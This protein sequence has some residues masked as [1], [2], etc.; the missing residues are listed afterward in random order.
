MEGLRNPV[1]DEP[2]EVYWKRRLIV[3]IGIVVLIALIWFLVSKATG[4]SGEPASTPTDAATTSPA[5]TTG[6]TTSPDPGTSADTAAAASRACGQE[7]LT[8]TTTANPD[9]VAAG[10]A[11]KFDV[12]LAQDGAG[13]CFLDTSAEGTELLITSGSD[14]IY[15]SNDCPEDQ[16]IAST[17]LVLEPGTEDTVAVTW[18]GQRSLP[19]CAP[20]TAVPGA[21]TYNAQLTVQGIESE[22]AVFRLK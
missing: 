8:V 19:D 18:N 20:E 16:A 3:G 11:V 21:G 14:R 4:S 2:P 10:S 17:Q 22:P 5:P 15:S 1:G 6:A 12:D 7:D 9:E 13:P